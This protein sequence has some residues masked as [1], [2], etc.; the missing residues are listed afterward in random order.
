MLILD[1]ERLPKM[2]KV[3]L[4]LLF[5]VLVVADDEIGKPIID[6]KLKNTF[7]NNLSYIDSAFLTTDGENLYVVKN[8]VVYHYGLNPLKELDR[9]QTNMKSLTQV[10]ISLNNKYMTLF[11]DE[12]LEV[13]S[14]PEYKLLNSKQVN[15]NTLLIYKNHII[16]MDEYD[17]ITVLDIKTLQ[18]QK[19]IQL[20]NPCSFNNP[21]YDANMYH[22]EAECFMGRAGLL[23]AGNFFIHYGGNIVALLNPETFTIEQTWFYSPGYLYMTKNQKYLFPFG[24][25]NKQLI[26]L[27][28][29]KKVDNFYGSDF[30]MYMY[31]LHNSKPLF[32]SSYS[33]NKSMIV[34]PSGGGYLSRGDGTYR[35][36]PFHAKLFTIDKN[37]KTVNQKQIM[38][39]KNG[40]LI[41]YGKKNMIGTKS[42][43]K[44]IKMKLPNGKIVP[45]NMKTYKKLFQ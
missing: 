18:E 10:N 16:T 22:G 9:C 24:G 45:L 23:L 42:I 8:H 34:L 21:T 36:R 5:V 7:E 38:V 14:L 2:R 43:L 41:L 3:L 13:Y 1:I 6:S 40:G 28:T 44:D 19:K 26:D 32:N 25:N 31:S 29:G 12:K 17:A 4:I 37:N 39:S 30:R 33:I 20:K 11:D 27:E 35:K 15:I